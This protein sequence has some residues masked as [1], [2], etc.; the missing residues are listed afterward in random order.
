[1]NATEAKDAV[2]KHVR[3]NIFNIELHR[4]TKKNAFTNEVKSV[5]LSKA[6]FQQLQMDR[7][8]MNL[9]RESAN[10]DNIVLTVISCTFI[11]SAIS[12]EL[13]YTQPLA[14]CT[15]AGAICWQRRT[16][17]EKRRKVIRKRCGRISFASYKQINT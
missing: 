8:L 15:A 9:L 14:I 6:I 13:N 12:T 7:R 5:Y 16:A 10:N 1:M 3:G 2:R 4:P 17:H 11:S